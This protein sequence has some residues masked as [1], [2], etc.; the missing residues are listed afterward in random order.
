[1]S[2]G[3]PLSITKKPLFGVEKPLKKWATLMVLREQLASPSRRL[4]AD[5]LEPAKAIS[6]TLSVGVI[7][8][9]RSPSSRRSAFLPFQLIVSRQK[10]SKLLSRIYLFRK[11]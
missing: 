4:V 10:I 8:S 1:L 6:S 7:D 5:V 9:T 11:T 2:A 3:K